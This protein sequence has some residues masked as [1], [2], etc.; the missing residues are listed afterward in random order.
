M[1]NY[2]LLRNKANKNLLHPLHTFDSNEYTEKMNDLFLREEF[3]R[4][5]HGNVKKYYRLHAREPHSIEMS[6]AYDID[7]PKC[8]SGSKLKVVGRCVDFHTLG[9]Y[10]CPVCSK[11]H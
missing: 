3:Y 6:L 11:Y 8:G 9:L 4:D 10:E 5:E 2:P 1:A 7:C